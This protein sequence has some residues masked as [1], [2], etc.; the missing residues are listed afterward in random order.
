MNSIT[1][2][3][4]AKLLV[5]SPALWSLATL[6]VLAAGVASASTGL[7]IVSGVLGFARPLLHSALLKLDA[8]GKRSATN[9]ANRRL[10]F[11]Q[12]ASRPV[13]AFGVL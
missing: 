13:S 4:L 5:E 12:R 11:E 9:A 6:V 8:D 7:L 3:R 10:P 1:N 2:S